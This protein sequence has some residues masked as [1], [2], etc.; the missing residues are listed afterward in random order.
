MDSCD[1]EPTLHVITAYLFEGLE[2]GI[3]FSIGEMVDRFKAY[4]PDWF[5]KEIDTVNK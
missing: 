2:Y 1:V 3:R 5:D 4:T